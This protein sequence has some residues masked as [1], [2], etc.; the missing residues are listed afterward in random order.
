MKELQTAV[1][2]VSSPSGSSNR[3]RWIWSGLLLA[4]VAALCIVP[5]PRPLG[6]SE[7]AVDG[8]RSVLGVSEPMA[9]AIATIALRGM[10]LAVIGILLVQAFGRAKLEVGVPVVCLLAPLLAI[11]AQWINYTYFPIAQQIW[12]GVASAILGVLL[13]FLLRRSR[14]AM[15]VLALGLVGLIGWAT[16]TGISDDLHAAARATGLHVLEVADGIPEGDRGFE[17]LMEIAFAY[18]EDNS[19]G[20]NPDFPNR[21]AILALGVILGE[22]KVSKVAKREVYIAKLSQAE[23]L[24]SRITLYGRRDLSQHFWVSSALAVISSDRQSMTVG[25]AKEMMDSAGGSGFSF[26]DLTADRA[27]TLFAL[28]ATENEE[29]ARAIQVRIRNGAAISDFVPKLLDLP[30]GIS[31][32]DFQRE[33]GGLRGDGTMRIVEEIRRRLVTCE[34]L[35]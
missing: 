24:R 32:E 8:M 10:G 28:A 13:G 7:W 30:E 14:I 15:A 23:E 1:G 27:G 2:K 11:M 25:L 26:V 5:D 19:H 17:R 9:R 16:S 20:R 33:Y 4:W 29:S 35:R 21:A 18:A 12:F 31:N 34:G 3:M 22:E 6:A